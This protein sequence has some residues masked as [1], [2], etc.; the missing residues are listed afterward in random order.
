VHERF[1]AA[2]LASRR[3]GLERIAV[4]LYDR[5]PAVR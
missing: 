3:A 2:V 1:V 5:W 4:V